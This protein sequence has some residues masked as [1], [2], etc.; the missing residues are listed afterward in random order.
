MISAATCLVGGLEPLRASTNVFLSILTFTDRV[1]SGIIPG[2]E[3]AN[4]ARVAYKLAYE[5]SNLYS[6][7]FDIMDMATSL[8][9]GLDIAGKHMNLGEI[10]FR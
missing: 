1:T 7:A 10:R 8:I 4:N 3:I 6:A 2:K 5:P 9:W